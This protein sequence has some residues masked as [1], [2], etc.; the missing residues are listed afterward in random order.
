MDGALVYLSVITGLIF[1]WV[2]YIHANDEKR[3][4][5]RDGDDPAD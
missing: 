2:L 4:R 3:R 5:T 1:V